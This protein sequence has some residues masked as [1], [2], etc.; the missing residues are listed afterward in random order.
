MNIKTRAAKRSG[1]SIKGDP[2]VKKKKE[3]KSM[4]L[5]EKKKIIKS[6]RKA[7]AKA[8]KKDK[9]GRTYI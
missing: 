2:K 5:K 4:S 7:N 6:S 3:K 9:K 8:G 1:N